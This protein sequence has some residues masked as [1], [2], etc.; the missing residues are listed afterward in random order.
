MFR[1]L[2][3]LLVD[4]HGQHEHQ[5]LL[6]VDKHRELFDRFGGVEISRQKLLVAEAYDC[7]KEL[8]EERET[9]GARDKESADR[10]NYLTCAIEEINRE[11]PVPGED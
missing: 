1:T 6:K 4:M 9:Q 2:G 8:A 7:L 5:S 11:K 3:E 10:I